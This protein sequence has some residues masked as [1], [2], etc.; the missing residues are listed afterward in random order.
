[1]V[2]QHGVGNFVTY[3]SCFFGLSGRSACGFG[4][5]FGVSFILEECSV[6]VVRLGADSLVNVEIRNV[7]KD[8]FV[9]VYV[10]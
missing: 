5:L 7:L 6:V 3:L 1:M 4:C 8:K 10:V 9:Y 2:G